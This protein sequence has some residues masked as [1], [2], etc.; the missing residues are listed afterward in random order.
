MPPE[1]TKPDESE[2]TGD[3]DID[4]LIW[5]TYNHEVREYHDKMIKYN[6]ALAKCNNTPSE[7]KKFM[8]LN[9]MIQNMI[10]STFGDLLWP[11]MLHC[12]CDSSKEG[13]KYSCHYIITNFAIENNR[14][15]M[16]FTDKV[17]SGLPLA[18]STVSL[19]HL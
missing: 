3:D 14:K 11:K 18:F 9:R 4:A 16:L 15:A 5:D 6:I 1:P 12:I 7:T 2:L 17:I 8:W 19:K 10:E 13:D